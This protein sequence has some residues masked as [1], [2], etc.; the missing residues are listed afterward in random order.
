MRGFA[1]RRIETSVE[2]GKAARLDATLEIG[3]VTSTLE[4]VGP[5]PASPAPVTAQPA[6]QPSPV[7][8][9]GRVEVA[10]LI[11]QPQPVYP[12]ELL[13]Q[14][15]EGTVRI[16]TTISRDGIPVNPHVLNSDEIDP[17]FAEAAL[18]SVMRWRYRPTKLNGEPVDTETT[19]DVTF[20]LQQ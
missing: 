18:D 8:V 20:A 3:R 14:G 7:S 4:V 5:K 9:G 12:P 17:R 10:L 1:R 19:I 16:R 11:R 2:S 6:P 15:V 13:Q